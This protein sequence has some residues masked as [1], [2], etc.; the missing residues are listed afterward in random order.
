MQAWQR[1]EGSD[2]AG[3]LMT[4]AMNFGGGYPGM[5]PMGV[6]VPGLGAHAANNPSRPFEQAIQVHLVG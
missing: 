3:Q 1:K 5:L 4:R 2:I 6:G